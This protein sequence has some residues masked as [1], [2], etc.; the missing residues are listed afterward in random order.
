MVKNSLSFSF[1]SL[2][3]ILF[4]NKHCKYVVNEVDAF[5]QVDNFDKWPEF[6]IKHQENKK[7]AVIFT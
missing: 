7:I 1:N 3:D 2:C 6:C 4:S 5:I